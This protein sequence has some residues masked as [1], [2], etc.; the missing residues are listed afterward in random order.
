MLGPSR[1][2]GAVHVIEAQLLREALQRVAKER[3]PLEAV[4]EL[5]EEIARLAGEGLICRGLLTRHTLE[6]RFRAEASR[7]SEAYAM[8]RGIRSSAGWRQALEGLGLQIEKLQIRGYLCRHE[9]RP[10]AVVHPKQRIRDLTRI[11]ADG[12]LPEGLLLR[13]CAAHG[14]PWGI[15]VADGRFRLFDAD[16]PA[17]ASEWLELDLRL[18]GEERVAYLALLG[19]RFLAG[20][21]LAELRAEAARFGATLHKRLDRTIRSE[22]LPALAAGMG[23]WAQGRGLDLAED[24]KREEIEQAALTLVFR[25]VFILYC[26][27]AGYLPLARRPYAVKSLSS[28]VEEAAETTELLGPDSCSLWQGFGNLVHAMRR[29]N[30][31]WDVPAYNG[32]LFSARDLRGAELLEEM[33]IPDPVFGR[34]LVALGRDPE[35]GLGTDFSTLEIAH[36]GHIYES[37][38]SLR[39]ALASRPLRY[40][41]KVDRYVPLDE[42]A[43][44]DDQVARMGNASDADVQAG[45]LLWQTHEGGRKAGGVY[46]TPVDIVRHLVERSVLPAFERRLGEV[47]ALAQTDPTRAARE[48]LEFAVVDPGVRQCA[49]PGSGCRDAG[50]TDGPVPGGAPPSVHL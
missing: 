10:V 15:L 38:L 16:S 32:A 19:P 36:I 39:L 5:S 26:E 47:A 29:G 46:Y 8:V 28:L 43:G 14:A 21:G 9:G 34:V 27:S 7:W 50:R 6:H 42:G 48:L 11:D 35:T 44:R 2:D 33:E 25:L 17:A 41:G 45:E 24:G 37:L 31:A 1:P 13:D 4:R 18:L 30:P 40:D 49:F 22:V 20:G 23:S 3:H 12:H